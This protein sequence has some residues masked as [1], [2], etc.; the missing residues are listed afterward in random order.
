M[1]RSINNRNPEKASTDNPSANPLPRDKYLGL[2]P[3]I[4]F[5]EIEDGDN[6][7]EGEYAEILIIQY[8][9]LPTTN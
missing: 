8:K 9:S 3:D 7:E 1:E 6:T 4:H 2:E 5:C